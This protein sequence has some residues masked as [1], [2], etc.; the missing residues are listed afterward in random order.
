MVFAPFNSP[1]V[2]VG[3]M[4]ICDLRG[5][6]HLTGIGGM[7]LPEDKAAE[8]QDAN[9]RLIAAAPD[10]L[11]ACETALDA[12][13]E[14]LGKSERETSSASGSSLFRGLHPAMTQLDNAI[15]GALTTDPPKGNADAG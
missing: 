15:Y 10:L 7:N 14:F 6:G 1:T 3:N 4:K 13:A 8:I 5:W 9:A 2:M 12:I 11:A